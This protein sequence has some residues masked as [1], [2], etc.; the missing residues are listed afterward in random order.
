MRRADAALVQG[1]RDLIERGGTGSA[2]LSQDGLKIGPTR[3]CLPAADLAADLPWLVTESGEIASLAPPLDVLGPDASQRHATGLGGGKGI[4][5]VAG[6]HA[7][8]LIRDHRHDAHRQPVCV[9]HVGRH[10]IHPR[11]LQPEE[12][13][14]VTG[15]P[16]QFRDHE[17]GAM[18][19]AEAQRLREL[20]AVSVLAALDLH[21][22]GDELPVATLGIVNILA[23]RV[24]EQPP[25]ARAAFIKAEVAKLRENLLEDAGSDPTMIAIANNFADRLAE[26]LPALAEMIEASDRGPAENG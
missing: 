6:D 3:R 8:L 22:L 14:R 24:V 11:L 7:A 4:L 20:W 5:R 26:W 23:S 17:G 13:V 19:A 1:L 18:H 15:E 12:E 25:S 2:D 10:K 16:I 9:R 21:D